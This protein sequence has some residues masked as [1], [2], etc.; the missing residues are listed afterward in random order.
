MALRSFTAKLQVVAAGQSASTSVTSASSS[1][2]GDLTLDVSRAVT[3]IASRGIN[4]K[5]VLLGLQ[6]C[7]ISGSCEADA[8]ATTVFET[9]NRAGSDVY[10]KFTF[11]DG[12][13]VAGQFAVTKWSTD[14]PVEGEERRTFELQPSASA[15][16]DANGDVLT[17]AAA[18]SSNGGGG[19]ST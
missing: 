15:T 4:Q 6:T 16:A 14:D 3:E 2:V 7:V 5:R 18:S 19:G 1:G 17:Y 13:S 11:A 10:A 12:S 9:A 8:A